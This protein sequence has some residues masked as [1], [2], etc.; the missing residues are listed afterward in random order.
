MKKM[1]ASQLKGVPQ[2][3]QDKIL[4]VVSEN[5]ELFQKIATEAQSLAKEKGL[6]Q[7]AAI[8]QVAMKYKSELGGL[9]GK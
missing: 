1:L 8:M 4:K 6:D 2:D 3:M 7:Q 5:P 9:F